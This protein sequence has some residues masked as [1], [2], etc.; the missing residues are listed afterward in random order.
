MIGPFL[1]KLIK[2]YL[3]KLLM[4]L[5][6]LKFNYEIDS[7]IDEYHKALDKRDKER[8]LPNVIEEGVFGED[9]WSISISSDY[10]RDST[11]RS[12]GTGD[13]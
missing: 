4:W 3:E 8:T 11:D 7:E 1:K 2:Y 13:T 10:D 9:G 5:R 6:M 12:E